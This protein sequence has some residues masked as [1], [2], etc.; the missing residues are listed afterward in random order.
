M[1][2]VGGRLDPVH[3]DRV[4]IGIEEEVKAKI[5]RDCLFL[6]VTM[7][8]FLS[9]ESIETRGESRGPIVVSHFLMLSS[10]SLQMSLVSCIRQYF[11]VLKIA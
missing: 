10:L 2:E 5:L 8:T 9:S 7:P 1:L 6:N 4:G 11:Q 3:V